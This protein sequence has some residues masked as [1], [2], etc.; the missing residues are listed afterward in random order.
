MREMSVVNRSFYSLFMRML[1]CLR[2]FHG[3][4]KTE[5]VVVMLHVETYLLTSHKSQV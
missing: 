4:N 3:N 5:V 1:K 2:V